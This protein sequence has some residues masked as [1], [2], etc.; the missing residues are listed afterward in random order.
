MTAT[1]SFC[2]RM[3]YAWI[4][5]FAAQGFLARRSLRLGVNTDFGVLDFLSMGPAQMMG[6]SRG[7]HTC[8]FRLRWARRGAKRFPRVAVIVIGC[9]Q[10]V[11][12]RVV[13]HV[14]GR[15]RNMAWFRN[16]ASYGGGGGGSWIAASTNIGSSVVSGVGGSCLGRH[17]NTWSA[18]VSSPTTSDELERSSC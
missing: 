9:R 16:G 13:D 15:L 1:P 14:D 4:V 17:H 11:G 18:S 5:A 6:V 12:K 7:R 2:K 3:F 8:D 10:D